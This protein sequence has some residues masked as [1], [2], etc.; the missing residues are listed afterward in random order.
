M[1]AHTLAMAHRHPPSKQGLLGIQEQSP[2]H[3]ALLLVLL[4]IEL[5]FHLEIWNMQDTNVHSWHDDCGSHN[6]GFKK[7]KSPYTH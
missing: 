6:G 4:T 7:E 3:C 1:V 2:F 5:Y